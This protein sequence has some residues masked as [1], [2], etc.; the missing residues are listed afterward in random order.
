MYV[1]KELREIRKTWFQRTFLLA[2]RLEIHV[3]KREFR[4]ASLTFVVL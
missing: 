2:V 1:E 3:L 4:K